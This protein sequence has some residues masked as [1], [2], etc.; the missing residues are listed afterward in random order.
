MRQVCPRQLFVRK[1]PIFVADLHL[2]RMEGFPKSEKGLKS[3]VSACYA[4]MLNGKLLLAGGCNFPGIPADEGGKK[5][6]YQGIY[7]AEMNPDT[8]FVW[9]KLENFP[10]LPLM[11]FLYPVRMESSV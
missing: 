7:V 3:G 2:Q 1:R 10:F 5:K 9:N 6:Y 11:A 4:G 8:V